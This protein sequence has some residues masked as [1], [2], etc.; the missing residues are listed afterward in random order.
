M[1]ELEVLDYWKSLIEDEDFLEIW[2]DLLEEDDSLRR[3]P[4]VFSS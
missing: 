4:A 1:N 2:E 3:V